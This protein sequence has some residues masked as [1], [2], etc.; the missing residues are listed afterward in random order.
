MRDSQFL[1][2]YGYYQGV[3]L[4]FHLKKGFFS[5]A[6]SI[7]TGKLEIF[8]VLFY[9]IAH[10]CGDFLMSWQELLQAALHFVAW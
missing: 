4:C 8:T 9:S 7:L 1:V 2:P 5:N 10:D 6:F 3:A